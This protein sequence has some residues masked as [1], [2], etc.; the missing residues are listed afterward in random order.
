MLAIR[1]I[2]L[3]TDFSESSDAAFELAC[4]LARN[5]GAKL[6]LLHVGEAPIVVSGGAMA[7]P[8]PLPPE[9]DRPALEAKLRGLKPS[10]QK[11]LVERRV[12]YGNAAIQILDAAKEFACDLVVMGTHGRGGLRRALLGSV[13]E[14][15]V[16]KAPCP[17]LTV[18]ADGK[19]LPI[20][21][22]LHATDFSQRSE[23]AFH[24]ACSLARDYG[25]RLIILH[26]VPAPAVVYGET[27]TELALEASRDTATHT[28]AQLK[29]SEPN[30]QFEHQLEE[31][32]AAERIMHAAKVNQ[33]DLIVMGTHGRT[34]LSRL[35]MGSVAEQV[36]RKAPCPVLTV[37]APFPEAGVKHESATPVTEAAV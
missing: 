5:H 27:V 35:V 19:G 9:Y 31:G 33:C 4:A 6:L 37:K 7:P 32:D 15:V 1:T 2:L 10:D 24:L 3:P 34:A 17:V 13:A 25:A 29:P 14:Q 21:R 30:V 22:L 20:R 11:L 16:R 8:A 28:L 23:F 36:V 18:R 26:V 12:V